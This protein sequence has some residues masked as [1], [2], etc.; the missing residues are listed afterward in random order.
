MCVAEC[1]CVFD[2]QL[3]M[4]SGRSS[5]VADVGLLFT[6]TMPQAAIKLMVRVSSHD[7]D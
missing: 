5:A 3:Q 4:I 2:E 6:L 1:V 7:V